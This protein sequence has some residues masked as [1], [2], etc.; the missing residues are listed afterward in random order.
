MSHQGHKKRGG[1][2]A[3]GLVLK[4]LCCGTCEGN[5]IYAD[6]DMREHGLILELIIF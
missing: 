4:D 3:S 6:T 1:V 5:H 2:N